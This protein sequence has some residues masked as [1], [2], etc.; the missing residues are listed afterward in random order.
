MCDQRSQVAQQ[1]R[2]IGSQQ[3]VGV[4]GINIESLTIITGAGCALTKKKQPLRVVVYLQQL[5]GKRSTI[6]QV[7]A[8]QVR[9]QQ[10]AQTIGMRVDVGDLLQVM[11]RALRITAFEG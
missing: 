7:S 8:L 9:L 5:L 3:P 2:R 11:D 10:V 1:F 4:A 6:R